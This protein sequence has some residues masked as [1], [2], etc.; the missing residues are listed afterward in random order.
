MTNN[1]ELFLKWIKNLFYIH[2]VALVGYMIGLLPFIGSWFGWVNSIVAMGT[3]FCL[4]KLMPVNE[5]YRKAAIFSGIAVVLSLITN[6]T[7]LG[8]FSI[9]ISVCNLV[10][11]YQEFCGHSEMLTG[12][13]DKLSRKWHTLFNWN[14]FGSIILGIIGAPVIVMLGVLLVLDANILTALTLVLIGGFEVIIRIVYLTYLKRTH[15]VCKKY[16]YWRDEI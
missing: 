12:I 6:A 16:E 1:K 3:V 11:L 9:V 15:D 2:C 7:D 4:Y 5:R 8:L 14:V 13:D 10:G